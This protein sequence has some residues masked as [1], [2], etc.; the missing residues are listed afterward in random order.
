MLQ[1]T[2]E[3]CK[4]IDYFKQFGFTRIIRLPQLDRPFSNACRSIS[5]ACDHSAMRADDVLQIKDIYNK[6]INKFEIFYLNSSDLHV[7]TRIQLFNLLFQCYHQTY[8]FQYYPLLLP[9]FLQI[10]GVFHKHYESLVRLFLFEMFLL[11]YLF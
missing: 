2:K 6:F 3:C 8:L 10:L 5:N 7:T 4:I 1:Q 9:F 11:F